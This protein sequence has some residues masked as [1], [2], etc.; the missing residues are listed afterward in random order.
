MRRIVLAI[1]LAALG[2]LAMSG[3]TAAGGGC[4]NE[5]TPLE[6]TSPDV[7]IDKCQFQSAILRVPVGT[8]VTWTNDDFLPHVVSGTGWG[9]AQSMLM[10]GDS[11]ARAF[12]EAGAFPYT[13]SLHPG[14]NGVVLVGDVV[15]PQRATT[16]GTVVAAPRSPA[17][18]DGGWTAIACMAAVLTGAAGVAAGRVS[19]GR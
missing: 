16:A 6:G 17:S 8:T 9:R 4:H 10:T 3:Q 12:T 1:A 19:A 5:A 15:T 18:P 2:G 13:C 11:F 14:M 7:R